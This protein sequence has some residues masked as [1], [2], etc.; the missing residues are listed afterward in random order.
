MKIV[1][2]TTSST[3]TE[4]TRAFYLPSRA[5]CW[6]ALANDFPEHE[7][8][9]VVQE[10]AYF[11][12]DR[13]KDGKILEPLKTKYILIEENVTTEEC[14]Q[15]IIDLNPDIAIAISISSVPFD[16]NGLKDSSIAEI[17]NNRGIKTI[18]NPV[19]TSL[20]FF[21]K[22]QTNQVLSNRGFNVAKAVYVHNGLFLA[23]RN[24][25]N[26]RNNVYRECVLQ[27]IQKLHYPVIIKPTTGSASF[28]TEIVDSFEIAKGKICSKKNKGDLI[29]E[30]LLQGEQ[31]GLEIHRNKDEY[32]VLPPFKL[33]VNT[34]GVVDPMKNIKVGPIRDAKYFTQLQNDLQK[35]SKE[36]SFGAITQ[37]DLIYK[38]NSWYI[39]EINPRWSGMTETIAASQER[40]SFSILLDS[41]VSTKIDYSESKNLKYSVSFKIPELEENILKE[42]FAYPY[43]KSISDF[44]LGK[45]AYREMV[46]VGQSKENLVTDIKELSKEFPLVVSDDIVEE[47]KKLLF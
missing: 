43:V 11:I 46:V 36:Y 35:L 19:E 30:E 7:L 6:D 17:L 25:A 39:I 9:V 8:V 23:E 22:W 2:Y 13:D 26:I 20:A 45:T 5:D 14:A 3:N 4:E 47:V 16:W 15:K 1:F 32:I 10:P 37:V 18:S 40:N 27:Q 28:R 44:P 41:I 34:E 42:L 24:H 33:S 12:I 21:D 31:F 29:V 38:D